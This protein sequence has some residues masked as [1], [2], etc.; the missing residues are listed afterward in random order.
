MVLYKR[1]RRP[2]DFIASPVSKNRIRPMNVWCN[3]I[4]FGSINN[5]NDCCR[6]RHSWRRKTPIH[7]QWMR[8]PYDQK[9]HQI[10]SRPSMVWYKTIRIGTALRDSYRLVVTRAF[11]LTAVYSMQT[12]KT[13]ESDTEQRIPCTYTLPYI[14]TYITSHHIA[15]HEQCYSYAVQGKCT[16]ASTQRAKRNQRNTEHTN[17][18]V[19]IF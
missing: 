18:K 16:Q 19:T 4:K 15:K 7:I 1:H 12:P 10:V 6:L 2:I 3:Q 13:V 9:K 17:T 8:L 11:P 14:H 5:N